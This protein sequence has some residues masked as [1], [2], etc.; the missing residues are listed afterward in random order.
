MSE[1]Q[2]NVA[3]P[4]APVPTPEDK[5]AAKAAAK[6]EKEAARAAAKAAKDAE[7]A[8]AKAAQPP[9]DQQNGITRPATGTKTG[10]VWDM[11]DHISAQM[12][13]PALREEVMVAAKEHGINEG[14]VAT[15]Y[16]R[17]T[18]YHGVSSTDRKAVRDHN[19]EQREAAAKAEKAAAKAAE[20][21]AAAAAAP[22]PPAAE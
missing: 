7:K 2:T 9:K 8:A 6:A 20:A 14:T 21:A 4:A 22:A 11:S 5:A 3:A 15:Q 16:A 18:K 17:W 13:R 12:K 19:R 1:E 10:W